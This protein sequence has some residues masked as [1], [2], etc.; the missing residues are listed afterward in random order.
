MR[1]IKKRPKKTAK[2]SRSDKLAL[3]GLII[4]V[5]LWLISRLLGG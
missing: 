1:K 3:T 4:A 2:W 5:M